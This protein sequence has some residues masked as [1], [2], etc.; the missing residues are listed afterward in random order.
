MPRPLGCSVIFY[1][2]LFFPS[3]KFYVTVFIKFTFLAA[4]RCCGSCTSNNGE[5]L[6][7]F[8][9]GNSIQRRHD[10]HCSRSATS[11]IWFCHDTLTFRRVKII[12]YI[13]HSYFAFPLSMNRKGN[14][15][16]LSFSWVLR[17]H[18]RLLNIELTH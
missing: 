13:T 17:E 18:C 8:V 4:H 14:H 1:F 11:A 3:I 9:M 7:E 6:S 15:I 2:S 12:H 5:S 10:P 16:R